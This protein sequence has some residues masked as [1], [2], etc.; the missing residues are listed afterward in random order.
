MVASYAGSI[1][2][3]NFAD[4]MI[5]EIIAALSRIRWPFV[6]ACNSSFTYKGQANRSSRPIPDP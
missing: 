6:I 3:V 2:S 5:E 1:A 4:G